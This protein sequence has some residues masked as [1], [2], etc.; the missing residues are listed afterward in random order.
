M[1]EVGENSR[2]EVV[3]LVGV[4]APVV[5]VGASVVCGSAMGT[6]P[7]NV[8]IINAMISDFIFFLVLVFL[9]IR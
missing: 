2:D 5:V 3:V 9:G 6:A 7:E 8:A 4:G 1:R